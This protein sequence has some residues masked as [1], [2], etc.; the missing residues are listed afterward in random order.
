MLP[1][2]PVEGIIVCS[3]NLYEK[4]Q[5]I[6]IKNRAFVSPETAKPADVLLETSFEDDRAI[7]RDLM[8]ASMQ[9]LAPLIEKEADI[10]TVDDL[11]VRFR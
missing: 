3:D 11:K 4:N 9:T 6:P 2:Q 5:I 1:R 7:V 10:Y 8:R